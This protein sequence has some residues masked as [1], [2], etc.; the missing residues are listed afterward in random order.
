MQERLQDELVVAGLDVRE[1]EFD[2]L[3][4]NKVPCKH[5]IPCRSY[6]VSKI[7]CSLDLEA[8]IHET[9]R[10]ARTAGA[11]SRVSSDTHRSWGKPFSKVKGT[12]LYL[13]PT[14]IANTPSKHTAEL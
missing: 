8:V 5:F 3:V 11:V 10:M 9:F 6:S 1:M 2:D 7:R 14:R 13:P 12:S 4:A